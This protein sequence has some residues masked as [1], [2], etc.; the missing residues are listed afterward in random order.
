MFRDASNGW[1]AYMLICLVVYTYCLLLYTLLS[2]YWLLAESWELREPI[3]VLHRSIVVYYT[4]V[5]Y[6][7]GVLT[8]DTIDYTDYYTLCTISNTYTYGAVY[9]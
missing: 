4:Y 6:G 1:H 2:F 3:T 9:Y 8:G 5:V 7:C